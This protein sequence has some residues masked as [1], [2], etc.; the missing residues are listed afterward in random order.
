MQFVSRIVFDPISIRSLVNGC[1][2]SVYFLGR[3]SIGLGALLIV[4][5]EVIAYLTERY[6]AFFAFLHRFLKEFWN[7]VRKCYS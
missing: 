5:P 7:L 1:W 6:K 3:V 4:D 2:N